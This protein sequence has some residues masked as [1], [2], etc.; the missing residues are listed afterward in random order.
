MPCMCE[1]TC[2]ADKIEQPLPSQ[3]HKENNGKIVCDCFSCQH[4]I[5]QQKNLILS[6]KIWY[7]SSQIL[8]FTK[9]NMHFT[10]YNNRNIWQP[11]KL[12]L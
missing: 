5:Y 1:E 3:K 9:V 2:I 7:N 12:S 6:L 11:P 8:T 4:V 10:S